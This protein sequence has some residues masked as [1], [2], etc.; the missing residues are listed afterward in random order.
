MVDQL[1]PSYEKAAAEAGSPIEQLGTELVFGGWSSKND[2]MMATACAKSGSQRPCV[3]QP[4]VGQ[5]ASPSEPL[6]P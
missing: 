3:V 1:W 5:P 6:W 4:I 2:R